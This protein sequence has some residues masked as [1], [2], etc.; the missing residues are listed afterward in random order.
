[1]DLYRCG[2]DGFPPIFVAV[3]PINATH[4]G[5]PPIAA[6]GRRICRPRETAPR[7]CTVDAA[8]MT[9]LSGPFSAF[10]RLGVRGIVRS[11]QGCVRRS[12]ARPDGFGVHGRGGPAHRLEPRTHPRLTNL[13]TPD[14][15]QLEG[16]ASSP[17]SYRDHYAHQAH[18]SATFA[19]VLSTSERRRPVVRERWQ[20]A[21]RPSP[22]ST[23]RHAD[24]HVERQLDPRLLRRRWWRDELHDIDVLAMQETKCPDDQFLVMSFLAS[25]YDVVFLRPGGFNGAAIALRVGLDPVQYGFDGQPAF[26]DAGGGP[27]H[28]GAM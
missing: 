4:D 1:M 20:A 14:L 21:A 11:Q 10:A 22:R 25:G 26:G 2:A 28:L 12:H 24:S 3:F 19:V 8:E 27:G 13:L 23:D 9:T 18:P 16:F 15:S 17:L 6:S 7:A 5:P